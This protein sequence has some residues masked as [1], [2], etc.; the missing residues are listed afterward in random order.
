MI[1][2]EPSNPRWYDFLIYCAHTVS[3]IVFT[4]KEDDRIGAT[5]IGRAYLPVKEVINGNEVDT[6]INILDEDRDPI[7]HGSRIHVRLKY[8]RVGQDDTSWFQGVPHTFFRQR[9]GCRVTLYPDVHVPDDSITQFLMSEGYFPPQRCWEDVFE[10]ITNAQHLIY[11]AGW[12]VYTQITLI[13]DPMRP[14]PGGEMVL[15]ELLKSKANNGVNVLLLVWDDRTSIQELKRDGLM[16]THDQDTKAY[17]QNTNVKCMLCP[18][19]PDGGSSIIQGLRCQ[20]CLHTIKRQLWWMLN[21]MAALVG[22]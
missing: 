17:F 9:Q 18:R 19:N 2:N 15:G 4:V 1:E 10:A 11:I 14:K 12:S 16:A 7:H 8:Y 22:G 3:N 20:P 21:S 6:W 13:R 5:L